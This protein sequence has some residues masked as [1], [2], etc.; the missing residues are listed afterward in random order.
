MRRH[1]TPAEPACGRAAPTRSPPTAPGFEVR[2]CRLCRRVL[3]FH[4]FPTLGDRSRAWC[5]P[6]ISTHEENPVA[7]RLAEVVQRG[8]IRRATPAAT[9][10]EA[11]P[12]I[13]F[14]TA[15][16]AIDETVHDV[17]PESL[18][19]LPTGLGWQRLPVGRSRWRGPPR[20]C[21]PRSATRWYYKRNLGDARFAP[22][23][24]RRHGA[25]ARWSTGRPYAARSTSPATALSTLVLLE[26]RCP[27]YFERDAERGWPPSAPSRRS[28]RRLGR[29][30]P[31]LVDLTGDGRPDC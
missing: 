16:V 18:E 24:A 26:R 30:Q 31:R 4:A 19:N 23:G 9:D 14:G 5:A 15:S 8:Y 20:A 3:M 6:S 27:G 11:L 25:V 1:P 2:T 13:A 28:Q 29:P 7:T 17:D 22:Q 21:S 12:P 10:S